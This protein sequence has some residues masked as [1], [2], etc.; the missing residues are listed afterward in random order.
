MKYRSIKSFLQYFF[1]LSN[2]FRR[3]GKNI[4]KV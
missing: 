3:Y 4:S 1:I 2:F